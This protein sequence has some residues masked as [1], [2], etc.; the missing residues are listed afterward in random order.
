[1]IE[2]VEND[3]IFNWHRAAHTT[4]QCRSIPPLALHK[5][6]A[7]DAMKRVHVSHL[8]FSSPMVTAIFIL[9]SVL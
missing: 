2:N 7:V 9:N 6:T 4:F 5:L 3:V 8:E 1:V